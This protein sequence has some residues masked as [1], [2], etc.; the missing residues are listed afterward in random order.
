MSSPP[1]SFTLNR[2]IFNQNLYK[3][4][5][6]IWF[7]DQPPN[8]TVAT[9]ASIRRWFYHP[10]KEAR[11]AFDQS[12]RS[13]FL[14]ALESVGPA[15][16]G[17]QPFTSWTAERAM[18]RDIAA[19]FLPDITPADPKSDADIDTAS[20]NA[21][22]LFILLDQVARNVFRD[23]QA[24]IY[25]HYDR[26]S[27]SLIHVILSDDD[28]DRRYRL[29]LAP[30]IR[31]EPVR[32]SWFYLPLMHSEA[33]ADHE[34]FHKITVE[35]RKDL[36]ARDDEAAAKSLD[37]NLAFGERHTDIIRQFGRYPYRN[38]VL[39]RETTEQEQKWLSEG[40]ERFGT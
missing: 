20:S 4:L 15:H 8:V 39:G 30:A 7:A 29:D 32:R 18:A 11:L 5:Q 26:L 27:Q 25:A 21:L 36:L 3:R 10:D 1:R 31:H 37:R 16:L 12:C 38:E 40:G 6:A 23:N 17:L 34:L 22:S 33:L 13:S 2:T 14:A 35:M 28:D 9:E 19:P 24:L